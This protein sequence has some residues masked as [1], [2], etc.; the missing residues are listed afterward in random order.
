M[1]LNWD[2]PITGTVTR[3]TEDWRTWVGVVAGPLI[4]AG[5]ICVNVG[6]NKTVY[7][8]NVVFAGKPALERQ[9]YTWTP[10]GQLDD[11]PVDSSSSVAT[12]I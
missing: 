7:P 12:I 2:G 4:V 10:I 5:T 11:L 8:H 3:L 1:K 6:L 9:W